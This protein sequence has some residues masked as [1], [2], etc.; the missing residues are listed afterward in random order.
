MEIGKIKE[1]IVISSTEE[2]HYIRQKNSE[3]E[4]RDDIFMPHLRKNISH[5][6][7]LSVN[8]TIDAFVHF[9]CIISIHQSD[10]EP[11]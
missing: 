2:G 10:V 8:E 11:S 6:L 5:S 9:I 1:F 4:S 7:E 3:N